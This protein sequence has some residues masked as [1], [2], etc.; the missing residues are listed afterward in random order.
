MFADP[1]TVVGNSCPRI[2]I[3][4]QNATYRNAAGTI[5]LRISHQPSKSR[6]RRMIRID[7]TKIAADPISAVNQQISAGVYFVVDSPANGSFTNAELVSL[8]AGLMTFV[9]EDTYGATNKLLGGES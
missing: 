4:D 2:K 5:Q 8:V 6:V 3:G 7:Q 1:Q 9:S